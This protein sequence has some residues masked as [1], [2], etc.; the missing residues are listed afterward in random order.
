MDLFD[1]HTIGFPCPHCSHE[2]HE[3]VG[4]LKADPQITCP[5]CGRVID[6]QAQGLRQGLADAANSIAKFRDQIGK[7][8]KG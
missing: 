1:S 5:S 7:L 6:V 2:L 4:R 3:K 8:G